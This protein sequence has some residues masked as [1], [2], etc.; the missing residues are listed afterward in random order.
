MWSSLI[1]GYNYCRNNPWLVVLFLS[2]A[3]IRILYIGS[4]PGG[5]NQDEASIGYDAFAILH[6]GIDRN[7]IH[8]PI[9]LISWGSGQNALYAY[10]SMPFILVFGLTPFS[11]R[12][13]SLL[14]GLLG[15]IVF[16][17]FSKALFKS[18]SAGL[19]A[20]FL[21]AINPWHI[22]MSRWALESN[23]LPTLILI[24]AYCA[25][26]SFQSPKWSYGFT[27]IAAL[28]LYAY[29]TAYFFIPVFALAVAA[30]L[31][32]N[33][34][35]T[36]RTAVWNVV[37]FVLLAL[38]ILLFIII[39]HWKLQSIVTLLFSIPKLTTPRVEEISSLFGGHLWAAAGANFR[40]F[41]SL[42]VSG[43]DGLPWNA[44][45]PYG[46][47]YPI[48]LPFA[49]VGLILMLQ[50]L[51]NKERASGPPFLILLWL[52]VSVLMS[53]ITDVNINRINVIFYPL[54]FLIVEGF[55]G[56]A[57]K[58]KA[59]GVAS[60][61]LFSIFFV[62]FATAYFRDY[63]QRIGPAFYESFGEAVQYASIESKGKI[64]VTD[65][66]NMPYI[67]VLFYE[68]VNPHDFIKTVKYMN[69][70]H[71]FQKVSSF[72]RYVFG[73]P[74]ITSKEKAAYIIWNGELQSLPAESEHFSITKFT[75]Y[76][77]LIP[78]G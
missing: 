23:V 59:A 55:L 39:N 13:V 75:N 68:K 60:T 9:H 32:Y 3:A 56:L 77:V 5:L 40:N 22:M 31:L 47:A 20:M 53:L 34:M 17:L 66:V 38:P 49:V 15:M 57:R 63:P 27:V 72:G 52:I 25:L 43:T 44:I 73:R 71:A 69:P 12:A 37:L 70:G 36:L 28:S 7:G 33:R 2:G 8:L 4:I 54:L 35:L 46:Y 61:A 1:G 51:W 14:M 29:G 64:Y 18:K 65:Q 50:S 62:L 78:E 10:L 67:H 76:T 58:V 26:K 24:A 42:I 6:Y 48:A 30:F 11:V 74:D 21:I 41:I 45:S 19:A 16:Y